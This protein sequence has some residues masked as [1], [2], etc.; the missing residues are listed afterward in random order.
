[1]KLFIAVTFQ[2]TCLKKQVVNIQI[3]TEK[4]EIMTARFSSCYFCMFAI[5][6]YFCI[7]EMCHE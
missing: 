5:F 6:P 1:M 7:K 4:K 2:P 3:D